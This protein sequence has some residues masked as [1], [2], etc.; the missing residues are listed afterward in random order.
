MFRRLPILILVLF[1]LAPTAVF[2][3]Q[4]ALVV[5]LQN[6]T[7]TECVTFEQP[8]IN[9]I[10]LLQLS[11]LKFTTATFKFGE[12]VCSI[13]N[14]GCQFPQEPCFCQCTSTSPSCLFFALFV[15]KNGQFEAAHVG[16]SHL[17]VH[18]GDVIALA[19]GNGTPPPPVTFQQ[20]CGTG[21]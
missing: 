19:F 2:A 7:I 1:L 10:D 9:V 8:V 6:R 3:N 16:E 18:D 15:L 4:A 20:V 5:V 17:I 11:G 12:A 13:Q 21:H 14:T